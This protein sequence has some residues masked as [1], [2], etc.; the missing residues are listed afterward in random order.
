MDLTKHMRVI[1]EFPNKGIDFYDMTPLLAHP[2]AY[3]ETIQ[4]LTHICQ[5]L[6]CDRIGAFDAR[7]FLFACPVAYER[8]EPLFL[9]RKKGKLP[10]ATI[11]QEYGLEY[12]KETLEIHIDALKKGERIVLIDDVLA[13][14]GTMKAGCDL[15]ERLGGVVAGC[16]VVLELKDLKGREM[17]KGYTVESLVVR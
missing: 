6:G 13:T 17:L 8:G 7:G 14:G 10:Y 4:L 5:T 2:E 11:S 9:L 3:N 15:V 12:G 16:A 1:Q